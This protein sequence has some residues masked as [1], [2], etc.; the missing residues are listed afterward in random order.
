META[1]FGQQANWLRIRQT[2]SAGTGYGYGQQK[3]A[4]DGYSYM[5]CRTQLSQQSLQGPA[6]VEANIYK[7][8]KFVFKMF[9]VG[10]VQ[11]VKKV[12]IQICRSNQG[13]RGVPHLL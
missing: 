2:E 10:T 5:V 3:F 4:R 13:L 1:G 12:Q 6:I 9:K 7:V 11:M 8:H